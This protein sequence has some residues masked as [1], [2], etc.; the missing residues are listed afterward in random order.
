MTQGNPW[1]FHVSSDVHAFDPVI[2]MKTIRRLLIGLAVIAFSAGF[3][4]P[5]SAPVEPAARL[6]LPGSGSAIKISAYVNHSCLVT[7]EGAA[8]CWGYNYFGPLGTGDYFDRSSPSPVSGFNR[9]IVEIAS[10]QMHSCALM[11]SGSVKCWGDNSYGELGDGTFVNS[12]TPV[13]VTGLPGPVQAIT[14]GVAHACAIVATN[15]YC[16]GANWCG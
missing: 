10:G 12:T 14:A 4:N 13:D 9:G 5:R 11:A 16:W 7:R 15:A 8:K 2:P 6:A 1:G 3:S